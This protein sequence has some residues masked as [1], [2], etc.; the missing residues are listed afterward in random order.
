MNVEN[1]KRCAEELQRALND[2][3]G[4]F[5]VDVLKLAAGRFG[6]RQ[7]QFAYTVRVV[8]RRIICGPWEK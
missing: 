5:D 3:G 2:A 8:E 6:S 7:Q 1:V 4:D